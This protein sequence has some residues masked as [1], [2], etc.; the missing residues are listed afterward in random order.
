MGTKKIDVKIGD[1][2]R[3]PV[4]DFFVAAKIIWISQWHKDATGIVIFPGWFESADQ[5]R[6]VEGD[7]LVMKMG[8]DDVRVL[9]PSIKNVTAKKKWAIIGHSPLNETDIK[10]RFHLVASML[11]D[12]DDSVR[13]ATLDDYAN[14]PH[15]LAAGPIVVQNLI[16]QA[17]PSMP[18]ID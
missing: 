14:Y 18:R 12:G 6:P 7:Y 13:F 5:V 16:R 4:D 2:L 11:Y 9:Y 1:I 8:K 17:R 15:V 10:L 3:I